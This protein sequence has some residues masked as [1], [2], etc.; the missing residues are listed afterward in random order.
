MNGYMPS[1]ESNSGMINS[2]DYSSS[3]SEAYDYDLSPAM[4]KEQFEP[5][6]PI[7]YL[8][9]GWDAYNLRHDDPDS[10]DTL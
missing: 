2:V 9:N 5:V 8:G 6:R 4:I 7:G 3:L 1:Q 10:E